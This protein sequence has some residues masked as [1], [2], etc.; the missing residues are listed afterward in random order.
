MTKRNLLRLAIAAALLGYFAWM[1]FRPTTG[2]RAARARQVLAPVPANAKRF[3][4]GTLEFS[5]CELAQ[6]RSGATTSAC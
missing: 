1:H 3:R 2:A 5:R 4:L 6:K